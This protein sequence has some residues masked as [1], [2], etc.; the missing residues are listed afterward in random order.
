MA[1]P[2]CIRRPV[3]RPEA[4]C[5]LLVFH[6]A[7]GSSMSYFK[8]AR[9]LAE[10]I[11]VW[12]VDC[13][14]RARTLDQPVSSDLADLRSQLRFLEAHLEPPYAVFGHSMGALVGF[15]FAYDMEQR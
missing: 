4:R 7:G 1:L 10:E 14:G 8:W 12:L 15:C 3:L 2:P 5:R 11:E 9:G 13:P 6:H